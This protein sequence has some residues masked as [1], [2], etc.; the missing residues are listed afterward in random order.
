M[1]PVPRAELADP[2]L[3]RP[4]WLQGD[5]RDPGRLW[6]DKNENRDPEW[7]AQVARVVAGLDPGHLSTYPDSD[8]LYRKLARWVGVDPRCLLLAAG[9]DG[10]I[11]SVFEAFVA[12]GD[13]VIITAPSF[14]MYSVY[15][16]IYGARTISL[17]YRATKDG[18][19]LACGEVVDAI[20]AHRPRLVCLPNPDSPTGTVFSLTELR[21]IVA[22]SGEVGAVMLIDEAYHPFHA[23]S[24][25]PMIADYPHL[26]VARTAA[27]AWGLAGLR[28]GYAVAAPELAAIL[29]K[30]RPMY[31]CA[32]LAI[33]AF[34][35]VLDHA[36]AMLASVARLEA[37]K[38][39]FLVAME[40]LGL[41]VLHGK[42][43]FL[44]VAFG[45]SA[46]AIHAALAE[47]C[48]YRRD[49]ADPCLQGFS[50]FTATTPQLF[51][52]VIDRIATTIE[53][54]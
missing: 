40:R 41:R 32:T 12:S 27:K 42:G 39:Q 43:N 49:F 23:D 18:P 1:I 29:H 45:P 34:E 5:H 26:V 9:S 21:A 25:I 53:G 4:D 28:I 20:R 30:T 48:Y 19:T 13:R 33:A 51:R 6:L 7:L 44:H 37:G 52:P 35:A 24:V 17:A 10:A 38:G 36:D 3:W 11:R 14:A 16:R 46:A 22:A 50:R 8:A 54:A 2:S 47:L 31:E 15:C